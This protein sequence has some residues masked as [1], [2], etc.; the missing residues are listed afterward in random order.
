MQEMRELPMNAG[1]PALNL[2]TDA[3]HRII[4][5]LGY[6]NVF[7]RVWFVGLE[8][9]LGRMGDQESL[10]NLGAR[11]EFKPT[12]DLVQAHLQLLER[13]KPVD[14]VNRASFTTQAWIWMARLALAHFESG[15]EWQ[16]LDRAKD[17]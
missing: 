13:G 6:G 12:M 5:F 8:E 16:D 11:G 14:I 15:S 9:G 7:A 17:Y 4:G 1:K 2:S 3:A 10:S